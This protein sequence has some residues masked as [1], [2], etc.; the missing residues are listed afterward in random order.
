[1]NRRECKALMVKIVTPVFT[2]LSHFKSSNQF[3]AMEAFARCLLGCAPFIE[4]D[5][6][7]EA[8]E[9]G[10]IARKAL[11]DATNQNSDL[12]MPFRI[13]HQSLVETGLM[14]Q[15]LLLAPNTLWHV[16]S[17]ETKNN[18]VNAFI[19]TR[20]IP[21][22]RNNWALFGSVIETFLMTHGYP[23]NERRLKLGIDFFEKDWY[24]GDGTYSDG[25]NFHFDYY[26]S[27]IIHP[28]L[29][30]IL[31]KVSMYN[32]FR[33]QHTKRLKRWAVILE[34]LITPD[35]SFPA[36]GRSITYRC[37]VFHA[38]AFCSLKNMLPVELPAPQAR[39][40]LTR[41]IKKTLCCENSLTVGLSGSQPRLAEK[42]IN[43]GSIYMC[44]VAFLPLG[45]SE[46][47]PFWQETCDPL[48]TSWEKAWSCHDLIDR[49]KALDYSGKSS[50]V[51]Y[52]EP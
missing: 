50:F 23:I 5:E 52:T 36:I 30:E 15:A 18:I 37:G 2:N 47:N 24:V 32:N 45:L 48:M 39:L 10:I 9:L 21:L 4:L 49:D 46:S 35:G 25:D 22:R 16:L 44:C 3:S 38:L 42:Y 17:K 8:K 40:A 27:I 12:F 20:N 1:M 31:A 13:P 26:N 7:T 29:Y 6:D 19:S 14:A 41:A 33:E 43:I 28:L 51:E 11:E 34:K